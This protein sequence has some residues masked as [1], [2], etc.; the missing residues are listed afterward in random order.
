[1]ATHSNFIICFN[2]REGSSAIVSM[3]SA[4][5]AVCVP[6]F[7]DLDPRNFKKN[8]AGETLAEVLDDVFRT[9]RYGKTPH[10][11]VL[12]VSSNQEAASIG[13]KIRLFGS[14]KD[15]APTLR[16][17]RVKLFVLARRDF[18]ELVSSLYVSEMGQV[19]Q[20]KVALSQHPQFRVLAMTEAERTRYLRELDDVWLEVRHRKLLSIARRFVRQKR[21]LLSLAAALAAEG[22]EVVPIY[23]E[24]FAADRI[25]F[26][27]AFLLELGF[28]ADWPIE[29][30]S[31]FVKVMKSPARSKLRCLG[32]YV[33]WPQAQYYRLLYA[34]ELRKLERLRRFQPGRPRRAGD[35]ASVS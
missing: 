27:R 4:Q 15:L 26:I 16:A 18:I 20:D 22:I 14:P 13:F 21:E 29:D 31:K 30:A 9:G 19:D 7:E 23:Y 1:M 10:D 24:D 32:W 5:K 35:R 17:H 3:L 11:K 2:Q 33:A 8:H 12:Y 34:L 25:G 6:L 28:P